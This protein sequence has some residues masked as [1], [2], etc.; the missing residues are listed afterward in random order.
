MVTYW[1]ISIVIGRNTSFEWFHWFCRHRRSPSTYSDNQ[2]CIHSDLHVPFELI[3]LYIG[4]TVPFGIV[5]KPPLH[6]V[7]GGCWWS[8]ILSVMISQI[9]FADDLPHSWKIEKC[10]LHSTIASIVRYYSK[11]WNKQKNIIPVNTIDIYP[12]KCWP[13]CV[14]WLEM[15]MGFWTNTNRHTFDLFI[16]DL[17]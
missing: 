8:R 16:F 15:K 10:R 6:T 11:W 9:R 3:N 4:H 7:H 14:D 17:D 12:T 1:S 2:R 13:W 5:H